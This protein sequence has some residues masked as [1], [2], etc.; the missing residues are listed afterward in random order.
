MRDPARVLWRREQH[1]VEEWPDTDAGA[2]VDVDDKANADTL[3]G[4][5]IELHAGGHAVYCAAYVLFVPDRQRRQQRPRRRAVQIAV[6][7][8]PRSI[9]SSVAMSSLLQPVP[10]RRTSSGLDRGAPSARVRRL[11]AA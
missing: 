5:V 1:A 10:I 4:G 11:P 9:R 7:G 3:T 6:R 8:K 2:N